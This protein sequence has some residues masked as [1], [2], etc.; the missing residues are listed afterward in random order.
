MSSG[1]L[2]RRWIGT[3]ASRAAVGPLGDPRGAKK[4]TRAI[5]IRLEVAVPA[6][7]GDSQTTTPVGRTRPV[8]SLPLQFP[9]RASRPHSIGVHFAK[10]G[11]NWLVCDPLI[12]VN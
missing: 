10:C 8:A 7:I 1:R 6:V 4:S 11:N 5:A 2:S 3:V 12:Q 9:I